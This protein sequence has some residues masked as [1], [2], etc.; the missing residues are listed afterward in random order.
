[1]PV[2]IEEAFEKLTKARLV[3]S[4]GLT[5]A[6]PLTHISPLYSR[7]KVGSIG[8]PLPSTEAR[9][10]DLQSRRP[11]SPGQIGE[12]VL[13][14]PQVMLGY[15]RD[16]E[17]TKAA[18]DEHGWLHTGD[19]ARMDEDGFFQIISRSQEMWHPENEDAIYPRDIE[20]ILYELPAVGEVTVA[21]IAGRPVA[22][23]RLKENAQITSAT[24]T[25]F[26]Q[27]RLPPAH[28]P[29]PIIFVSEFPRTLIGK[30]LRRE[31][32]DEYERQSQ[33]GSGGVGRY[34]PGLDESLESIHP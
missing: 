30:V 4:Y 6:S 29:R 7:D 8:L 22:F 34:L 10:I 26:C 11:L 27:R 28:V 20:E 24:I 9:I 3:E 18:I 17:A 1:L 31:L 21:I 25:A 5:E 15:W 13:R 14:G 32:V 2:E 23:I 16:A 12:L 33:V 19:I